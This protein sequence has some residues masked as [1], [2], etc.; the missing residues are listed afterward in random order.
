MFLAAGKLGKVLEVA[1][2]GFDKK[3]D[4]IFVSLLSPFGGNLDENFL[5]IFLDS[6]PEMFFHFGFEDRDGFFGLVFG[7]FQIPIFNILYALFGSVLAVFEDDIFVVEFEG[8]RGELVGE[9]GLG[10]EVVEHVKV[11]V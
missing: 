8:V 11:F 5:R 9:E 1:V 2:E 6:L 3:F 10:G 7:V 4:E